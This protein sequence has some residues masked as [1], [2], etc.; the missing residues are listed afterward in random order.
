MI[1]TN[2]LSVRCDSMF[3]STYPTGGGEDYGRSCADNS[4]VFPCW[5]LRVSFGFFEQS[6]VP[7]DRFPTVFWGYCGAKFVKWDRTE[8]FRFAFIGFSW[9]CA[10]FFYH[11]LKVF[12][13]N[14]RFLTSGNT[15]KLV[16]PFS[17]CNYWSVWVTYVNYVG[18]FSVNVKRSELVAIPCTDNK[19]SVTL[20]FVTGSIVRIV[21]LSFFVFNH[22]LCVH[23]ERLSFDFREMSGDVSVVTFFG[24]YN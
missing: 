12:F 16:S 21:S 20:S 8:L 10:D 1:W 3:L 14:V 24:V 7:I 9:V 4:D 23:G 22:P 2:I 5:G 13:M 19:L 11:R 15:L 6:Y 17:L 18:A